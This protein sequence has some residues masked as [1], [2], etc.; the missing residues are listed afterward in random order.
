MRGLKED[1]TPLVDGHEIYYNFIKPHE[2]LIGLTP[3]KPQGF[4]WI[5][6]RTDGLGCS[7]NLY[8]IG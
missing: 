7:K 5:S 2:A 3:P 8:S 1:D 6:E 4:V